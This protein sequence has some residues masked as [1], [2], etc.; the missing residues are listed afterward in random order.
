LNLA[1]SFYI[2]ILFRGCGKV[3]RRVIASEANQSRSF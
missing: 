1:L 3:L 2:L